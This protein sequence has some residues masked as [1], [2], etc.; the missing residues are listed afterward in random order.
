MI[1]ISVRLLFVFTFFIL[2]SV[3]ALAQTHSV[4]SDKMFLVKDGNTQTTYNSFQKGRAV[5]AWTEKSRNG[6]FRAWV[7]VSPGKTY[8]FV[9]VA[10][11]NSDADSITGLWDVKSSGNLVCSGC[12]GK[13]YGL[14]APIGT[15]TNYFKIYVGD[16]DCYKESWLFSGYINKG[17]I[18]NA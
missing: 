18:F 15:G 7:E 2:F 1:K 6:Y 9:L 14:N 8:E 10:I 11:G 17:L 4:W 12:V 16:R 5:A 3:T 13:A